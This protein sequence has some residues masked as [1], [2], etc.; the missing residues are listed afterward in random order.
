VL[1][2]HF[3]VWIA[4]LFALM[5]FIYVI[6]TSFNP[7][8][9]I[10]TT[11]IIPIKPTLIHYKELILDPYE[12]FPTW[13]LNTMKVSL[14][15]AL[16]SVFFCSLG[17]YAFS[18]FRFRGR[19]VCLL[20]IVIIQI[21]PQTLSMVA[22]FKIMNEIGVYIPWLGLNTHL[23]L[24]MVY[25]GP[26]MGINT[27]LM[28]G[29]FDSIP[30][31]LEESALIDGASYFQAFIKIVIPLARPILSV[32]FIIQFIFGYSEFMLASILLKGKNM[33]TLSVGMKLFISQHYDDRWGLFAAG[34]VL[35][36]LIIIMFF[37]LI[38]R[39]MV[40]GLTRGAVRE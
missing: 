10:G 21:F 25:L 14:T 34:S 5:P 6:G 18:R 24:I 30:K 39:E 1:A 16:I 38:Q 3:I 12:P 17:A 20:T 33:Y 40:S 37:Y 27:W 9:S 28:K 11:K 4:I 15:T 13:L 23:G 36:S 26:A 22:I 2:H 35:S 7:S 31:S 19:K 29:Y 32:V 8:N